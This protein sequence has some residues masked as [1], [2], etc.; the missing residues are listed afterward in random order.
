MNNIQKQRRLTVVIEKI[1]FRKLQDTVCVRH[2]GVPL[3]G[4]NMAANKVS[5]RN[6]AA[7]EISIPS[8]SSHLWR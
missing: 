4:T 7:S 6:E 8:F 3:R 1:I 5:T 2:V